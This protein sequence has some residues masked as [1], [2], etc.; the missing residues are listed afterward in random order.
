MNSK[1]KLMYKQGHSISQN[2]DKCDASQILW[3]SYGCY[4]DEYNLSEVHLA[5]C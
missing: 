5:N 3:V 1:V 4:D 2:R